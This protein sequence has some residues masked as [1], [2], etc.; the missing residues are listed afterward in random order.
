MRRQPRIACAVRWVPLSIPIFASQRPGFRDRFLEHH[1][2]VVGDLLV[3][4]RHEA[5]RVVSLSALSSSGRRARRTCPIRP[6]SGSPTGTPPVAQNARARRR[7]AGGSRES[8][9]KLRR[10][11]TYVIAPTM[12][13]SRNARPAA[14]EC[15]PVAADQGTCALGTPRADCGRLWGVEVGRFR[16]SSRTNSRARAR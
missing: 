12:T 9:A 3:G 15:T 4:S 14:L 10:S 7:C 8:G 6:A 16:T 2:G 1:A 11:A 13:R 5:G